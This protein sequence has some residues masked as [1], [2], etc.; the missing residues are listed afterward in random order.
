VKPDTAKCLC[1]WNFDNTIILVALLEDR[2]RKES[3]VL[4]IAVVSSTKVTIKQEGGN[5]SKLSL[6]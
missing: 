2:R 3:V 4:L 6:K 1:G 5:I